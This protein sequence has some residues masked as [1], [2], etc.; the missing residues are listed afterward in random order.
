M[1]TVLSGDARRTYVVDSLARYWPRGHEHL[2]A[3]PLMAAPEVD[4]E[5]PPR[6]TLV[7]LPDWAADLGIDGGLL[8]PRQAVVPGGAPEWIRTNWLGAAFW[9]LNG[10]AERAFERAH[11]PI[12]SYSYRLR[13]WDNR[14][15]RHAW[16]N[17]IALWLR[18]WSARERGASEE[19]LFG[20]RPRAEI[21]LTHDVDAVSKTLAIRCKQ[22]AFQAFKALRSAIRG[23]FRSGAEQLL[24][25]G[26]FF[27][28][29]GNY[30]NFDLITDCEQR[31]GL[32][33]HFNFYGGGG[34]WGRDPSRLLFD[35]SY[36]V[37]ES[38][39]ATLL[40]DLRAGGWTVGLHQS[41][42]S[43]GD[44]AEMRAEKER[45]EAS[46]G[47]PVTSCRQHWLRFSWERTWRAQQ[48]AG[49]ALDTTL[50]FNDRAGFRNGA[51]LQYH[52]WDSASGRPLTLSALP[53]VLMD[54][55]VYDY[56]DLT[57]GERHR[58]MHNW[59]EEVL[60]V[61]GQ[62]SVIWHPHSLANDYGWR[63]GFETFVGMIAGGQRA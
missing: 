20:G 31:H 39:L 36:D 50:G 45:V 35:P 27:F 12:H 57:E 17:R 58:D 10:S 7:R 46:L 42:H 19:T 18:R 21:V 54:S 55:H 14:M 37:R 53:V 16:V 13:G 33:G 29:Q 3:L 62:A 15:W 30:W 44:P 34:K 56:E 25:A 5:L 9:Y 43:W 48:E 8:V 59:V 4:D 63:S 41:F 6:L 24:A 28:S 32:R 22:S 1:R 26:R 23:R 11:G 60:G 40:R 51:A 38:R 47:A 52:P 49:L 61:G 2:E